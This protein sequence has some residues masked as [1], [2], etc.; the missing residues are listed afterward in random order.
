MARCRGVAVVLVVALWDW[1]CSPG[2][3]IR[4]ARLH[5]VVGV[6]TGVKRGTTEG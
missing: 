5:R 1:S 3:G 4:V 2:S 6:V